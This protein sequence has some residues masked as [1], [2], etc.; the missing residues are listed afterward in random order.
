ML[1]IKGVPFLGEGPYAIY[2]DEKSGYR[3][4]A[5]DKWKNLTQLG[6]PEGTMEEL[7]ELADGEV[8]YWRQVLLEGAK[9]SLPVV[10][11]EGKQFTPVEHETHAKVETVNMKG[12]VQREDSVTSVYKRTRSRDVLFSIEEKGRIYCWFSEGT[13]P[14]RCI[15]TNG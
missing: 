14:L 13:I 10:T 12:E 3:S 11:F 15:A 4:D 5:G 6:D 2:V 1:W 9:P 7:L 8:R